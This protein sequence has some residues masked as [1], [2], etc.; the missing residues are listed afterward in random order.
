MDVCWEGEGV[1]YADW[2]GA[3]DAPK[4]KTNNNKQDVGL[5]INMLLETEKMAPESP[6]NRLSLHS[7]GWDGTFL[8]QFDN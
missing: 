5:E 2:R 1:L 6:D 8:D 7:V 4:T 3:I